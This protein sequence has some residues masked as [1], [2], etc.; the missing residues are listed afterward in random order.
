M[1]SLKF[2]RLIFA[3]LG[4]C[5]FAMAQNIVQ[6]PGFETGGFAPWLEQRWYLESGYAHTGLSDAETP[7]VGAA[8]ITP[9]PGGGAWLYQDLPTTPGATYTLTFWYFPGPSGGDNIAELQVLWGPT[10][11]Q[12]TTGGAGSCTGNC[13]FDN[14]SIGSD[15]YVQ[16]TVTNLVATSATTRLEFLGRQDPSADGLDDVAVVL[17]QSPTVPTLSTWAMCILAILL[18]CVGAWLLKPRF[19]PVPKA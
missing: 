4:L 2:L 12:L 8:C 15:T 11:T 5:S 9:A 6:N 1:R 3:G 17:T 7:C 14:N 16:Y 18:V 10:A 13:V 19:C